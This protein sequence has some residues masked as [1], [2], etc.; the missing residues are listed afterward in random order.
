MRP[1]SQPSFCAHPLALL[2][3]CFALG[4]LI[5]HFVVLP[6]TVGFAIGV[7]CAAA[8]VYLYARRKT[9]WATLLIA[10]AFMCAGATLC[11]LETSAVAENRVR[12]FYDDGVIASGDPVEVTG[13]LTSEPEPGPDGFYLTLRAE[14]I[15]YK[16]NERAVSGV[17]RLFAPVRDR[18]ARSAYAALDLRYGA[19]V[20]L[21]TT[22]NREER[23]RNPGGS[24][25]TE[26][27]ERRGYDAS[28]VLK[29]HL[30][31][32]RLDD[33]RVFLPLAWLY[34]WR[35]FL[36]AQ[37]NEKFSPET[38][39]VLQAA[40]LG[41][42][43]YLSRDA[44]ER[45][46]EAG[47]FHVL[48]ISGLHISFIGGLILFVMRRITKR[49]GWQFIVS[50]LFLWAYALA[51][52]AE[53]S[54]VRAALMFTMIAL[55]PVV[56][57]RAQAL[58]ALGGAALILLVWRPVELFDA[59]FQ[60]TFLSVLMIIVIAWPLLSRLKEIG[61]WRPTQDTPYPPVCPRWLRVLAEAL[62]WSE[63]EW[64]RELARATYSC[65]LFKTPVAARL[66]RWHMQR[67]L[68]YAFGASIVSISVQVGLLPI[69]ILYFHRLSLASFVLNI[70]VGV[71]M[72]LLSLVALAALA[73]SQ[74]SALLAA[75]FIRLAEIFNSLMTHSVDPFQRAGLASLRVPE[76]TNWR[77]GIY[78]LYYVPLIVLAITLAR[79][80][81]LR[82]VPAIN[83]DER[84]PRNDKE[85]MP[86]LLVVSRIAPLMLMA[87]LYL[88]IAHPLSAGNPDGRLRIDFLD[89]GQGDA[90]LVT[91][92]DGTTLLVDGGGRQSF[93][94][95]NSTSA[96]EEE[97]DE[98]FE[99]DTRSIGEAVVSEYLWWRGLGRIDY[100][101]ATHADADH[102]EGLSDVASN[103]RVRAALVARAPVADPEFAR[104][105]KTIQREGVPIYFIGLGDTLRFGEIEARVLWPAHSDNPS[106]A[107]NNN[108]SL[109]LQLRC[110][111]RVFLLTGDIEKDA[112]TAL[113]A[114]AE[115]LRADVVKVA[116]HGSRTSSIGEFVARTSA[117]IAV[118]SVGRVSIFGHPHKEVLERWRAGGTEILTT[119][120]RGTITI[121]TDGH[122]LRVETFVR[123]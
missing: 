83:Q 56:S 116:H 113:V 119:G 50:T 42:R 4:I 46:R 101:L 51:V 121:S 27:L 82:N 32:E 94:T 73:L 77:A 25:L 112:E 100:I 95:R 74:L 29:S 81:P 10:I 59:S 2:A 64:Q 122:D 11:L 71:L 20:R 96:E 55:A 30:L 19:R 107:S 91:M 75:P 33:E 8:S 41:N 31:I 40:L 54:V 26:F 92:P 78:V 90:A 45:F 28:G 52:G 84:P 9:A 89:V 105:S 14:K 98:F 7:M 22:L 80:N 39:G 93:S 110:G 118:I 3:A 86:R 36:L 23:F 62:F 48:V 108:D 21:M 37:I 16:E 117:R 66:E 102:I 67:P 115:D 87:A 49:R 18:E 85:A 61:A 120:R 58:N 17:V 109:V 99:R 12:R 97:G 44:S 47:T 15:N 60:L 63:R 65:R 123:D 6:I 57:R 88:V 104:F 13:V 106:A 76:Y 103:F 38:S 24:S 34:E 79:W 69:L 72:A 35:Q 5:A 43:Y 114:T 53:S 111:D 70:F 1:L 68:R